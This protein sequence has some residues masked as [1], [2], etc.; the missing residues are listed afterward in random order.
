MKNDKNKPPTISKILTAIYIFKADQ[1]EPPKLGS[2][3]LLRI[4]FVQIK[5]TVTSVTFFLQ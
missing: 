4:I 3:F 5:H 2:L 1:H